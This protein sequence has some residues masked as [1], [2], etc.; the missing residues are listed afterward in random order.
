[1]TSARSFHTTRWSLVAR[2]AA[3]DEGV[4][5]AALG[6]LCELYWY[7]LYAWLRRSGRDES[8]AL[9]LV[10]SFCVRLLE[11]GGLDGAETGRGAF[12]HYLLGALRH[13]VANEARREHAERRGGS[14]L[15]WSIDDAEARYASEPVD[16]D[17][18]ERLYERRWAVALL[19]RAMTRLR[20]EYRARNKGT[21]LAALEPV[22][23]GD[24]GVPRHADTAAALG[25]SEGA[26]KVAL[27]RL[28]ARLGELVRDEVAQTL[29]DATQVEAELQHLFAAL[30]S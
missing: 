15:P 16:Q 29:D 23:L 17:S 21:V 26:V 27:H 11:R 12:R 18:P 25:T 24:D 6:E 7:P 4:A 19:D 1:M 28:R 3:G 30:G 8:V 13:F 9:D 22:L 2:A 10:Q 5:R 20:D 14:G